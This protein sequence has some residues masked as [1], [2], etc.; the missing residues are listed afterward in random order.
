MSESICESVRTGTENSARPAES[1]RATVSL[2][3]S[4]VSPTR[5][6]CC[7]RTISPRAANG[8]GNGR[9]GA[10]GCIRSCGPIAS[11]AEAKRKKTTDKANER[12][13]MLSPFQGAER[14]ADCWENVS[15]I[16][17]AASRQGEMIE[18]PRLAGFMAHMMEPELFENTHARRVSGVD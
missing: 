18:R 5:R 17:S 6:H 4:V 2:V 8:A 3:G 9:A 1:G 7:G 11:K 16:L 12:A 15:R 13:R 10:A 14:D